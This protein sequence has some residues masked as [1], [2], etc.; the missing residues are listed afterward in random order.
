MDEIKISKA[1]VEGYT[2]DFMDATELDVAVVGGG[3]SGMASAYYLAKNG[4]KAAVFERKLSVGGGM[5]GGGMG[6]NKIVVQEEGKGILDEFGIRAKEYEKGYYV[7]DSLESVSAICLK[8]IRAGAKIFNLVSFEDVM[9]R[10]EKITGLVINWSAIEMAK[11]HVDPLT[12]RSKIV[13]DATGHAAEVCR[14]VVKKMGQKLRTETGDLLGEKPMHAERGEK[15]ILDNT[16][17][18]YPG[19][20]VAGMAANAAY[21]SP[22][23]GPIFGGM[24]LSGRKSAEIALGILGR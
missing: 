23:M 6:F 2:R 5:W 9:V 3:P 7:A 24:L 8:T 14:I 12:I 19:L 22:R 11:L 17:E 16:R 20:I 21:G 13:I 4:V 18:I 15:E 1:I 10:E